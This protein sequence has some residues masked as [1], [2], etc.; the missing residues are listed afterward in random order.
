MQND[1]IRA[2]MHQEHQHRYHNVLSLARSAEKNMK[3]A[4]KVHDDE[5]VT[6]QIMFPPLI[7]TLNCFGNQVPPLISPS[8]YCVTF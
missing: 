6:A 2:R 4:Q 8:Y 7:V 5:K 3:E 1:A